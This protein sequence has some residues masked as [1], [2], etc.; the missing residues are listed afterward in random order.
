MSPP[1]KTEPPTTPSKPN[2]RSRPSILSRDRDTQ[3]P[4]TQTSDSDS[5][6]G[7]VTVEEADVLSSAQQN[8]RRS[9]TALLRLGDSFRRPEDTMAIMELK[10]EMDG[11]G[12]EN[13]EQCR[14]LEELERKLTGED[15]ERVRLEERERDT[16]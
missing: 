8:L 13:E 5:D 2:T 16:K 6:F 15:V 3:L 12:V 10:R 1:K 14:R 11:K 4:S 7:I 9:S